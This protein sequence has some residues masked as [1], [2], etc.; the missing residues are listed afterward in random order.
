VEIVKQLHEAERPELWPNEW[1]LHNNDP[2]HKV[3]SSSF[4]YKNRLL[5]WNTHPI[6][7]IW[8]QITSVSKNKVCIKGMKISGYLKHLKN[9]IMVLIAIPEQEFQK[10]F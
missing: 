4:W 9:V 7:L 5:K 3:L 2:A 8:L 10:C 6:P 1:I